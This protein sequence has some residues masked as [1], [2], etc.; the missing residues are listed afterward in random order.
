M[1]EG[2]S[3]HHAAELCEHRRNGTDHAAQQSVRFAANHQRIRG[4]RTHD[5]ANE[6]GDHGNENG[7]GERG[8]G[9]RFE[10]F[11]E[12]V[13]GKSAVDVLECADNHDNGRRKQETGGVGEERDGHD[14]C[15][16][17]AAMRGEIG[18]CG[19][20]VSSSSA[21]FACVTPADDSRFGG[22]CCSHG[23]MRAFIR[24]IC[25]EIA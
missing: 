10:E 3:E 18:G 5:R 19:G 2:E 1:V 4:N 12:V 21:G 23:C 24:L 16:D 25:G 22:D 8:D 14:E 17:F 13:E 15:T 20:A 11:T 9:V 7:G 6:C